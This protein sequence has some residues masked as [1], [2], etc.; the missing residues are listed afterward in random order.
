MERSLTH[1]V[2]DFN[3][4]SLDE[5]K[6]EPPA[7]NKEYNKLVEICRELHDK[8]NDH[9]IDDLRKHFQSSGMK[10]EVMELHN[11]YRKHIKDMPNDSIVKQEIDCVLDW[12]GISY[13]N[14]VFDEFKI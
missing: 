14:L 1:P 4:L 13:Y 12:L 5:E 10:Y 9:N 2:E 3:K 8:I 11:Y 7:E 6:D